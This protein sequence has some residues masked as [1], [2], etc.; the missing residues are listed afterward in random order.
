MC[1]G[2]CQGSA[3]G[4]LHPRRG[5]RRRGL[6]ASAHGARTAR[7]IRPFSAAGPRAPCHVAP[8]VWPAGGPWT[9]PQTTRRPHPPQPRGRRRAQVPPSVEAMPQLPGTDLDRQRPVPGRQRLRLDGG[10]ADVL[11]AAGPLR[12]RDAEHRA[13]R[14]STP[15]SPTAT[16]RRSGSSAP[17]WPPAGCATAWS[18]PRRPRRMEKEHP[19]A[20][21]EIRAG[22]RAVAA[23][24]AD[25]PD[26]PVLRA[27]RRRDDAAGGDAA[28][29]STSW[30]R[31]ARSGTWPRRTTR[32][33]G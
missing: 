6:P 33:S 4:R 22:G 31:R 23:Q 11:R 9:A 21:G 29:R 26:R 25:R 16:G 24:P 18:W 7:A 13:G 17:G 10:R 5:R 2:R 28:R 1:G 19:L 27:L 8:G 30:C 12:R 3:R 20:A 32:R 15:R 14:S